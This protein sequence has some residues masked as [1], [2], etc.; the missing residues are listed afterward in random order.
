MGVGGRGSLDG[1]GVQAGVKVVQT[2]HL[3][4]CV[5]AVRDHVLRKDLLHQQPVGDAHFHVNHAFV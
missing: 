5:Q 2:L 4:L 1:V 3:L